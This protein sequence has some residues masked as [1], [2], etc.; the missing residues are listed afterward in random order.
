MINKILV[1]NICIFLFCLNIQAQETNG[2][3][4][5]ITDAPVLEWP[6][7]KKTGFRN[8]AQELIFNKLKG[9]YYLN[10]AK[11]YYLA[12]CNGLESYLGK[13][14]FEN[15]KK[16]CGIKWY[17]PDPSKYDPYE[18]N[19]YKVEIF[20]PSG[21][22][23]LYDF[24]EA[25]WYFTKVIKILARYV[26]WDTELSTRP[27]YKQLLI[28]S[29]KS[30]VYC[31]VYIGNYNKALKYL[32]EYK[33]FKPD[34]LF[35]LEWEARIYGILVS[36]AEKYDWVFVGDKSYESLKKKHRELL[37]KII[38]VQYPGESKTKEELKMRIYPELAISP[39][40]M[41]SN[42]NNKK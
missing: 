27:I 41:S 13:E 26:S 17:E 39:V 36:I 14:E 7:D 19:P 24:I 2:A 38:D 22:S 10:K 23:A 12:G 16:I 35:I 21:L 6:A 4:D 32:K 11:A 29:F 34:D 28:N 30:L 8:Y 37:L 33:K 42:T 5:K 20:T 1:I 40:S 31:N 15:F 25:E 9:E 3:N 18:R